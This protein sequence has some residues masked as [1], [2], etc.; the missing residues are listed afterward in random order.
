M[1]RDLQSQIALLSAP[2]NHDADNEVNQNSNHDVNN[3]VQKDAENDVVEV[4]RKSFFGRL[5][6]R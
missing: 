5:F 1:Q 4:N 6:G 3:E 2:Q